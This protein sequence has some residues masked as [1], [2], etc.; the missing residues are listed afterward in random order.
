MTATKVFENDR[1]CKYLI[2][3]KSDLVLGEIEEWHTEAG[4]KTCFCSASVCGTSISLG[5]T[6]NLDSGIAAVKT[7]WENLKSVI[8]KELW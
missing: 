2:R 4:N 5:Y 1:Y 6:P 3:S 8:M 7:F